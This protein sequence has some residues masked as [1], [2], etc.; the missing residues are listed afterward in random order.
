[1]SMPN[2]AFNQIPRDW[3]LGGFFAEIDG[4]AAATPTDTAAALLIGQMLPTGIAPEA[5]PVLVAGQGSAAAELFGRGSMLHA[6]VVA[7]RANNETM[8][9]YVIPLADNAEGAAAAQT[10]TV[11]GP[12]TAAGTIALWIA[13]AT[14]T[15]IG[16]YRVSVG[17]ASGDAA[18][19]VAAAIAT[20]INAA[21]DLPVTAAAVGAVVTVT[22]RHK[23]EAANE[24]RIQHSLSGEIG[25]EALPAGVALAIPNSG[26][27]AGGTA[28]PDITAAI[29]AMGDINFDYIGMPYTDSAS[30]NAMDAEMD[31]RWN[32]INQIWGLY[33]TARTASLSGLTTFGGTRNGKFGSCV[34]GFDRSSP[35]YL[36][37]ARTVAKV[38]AALFN[39][40]ARALIGLT[41]QGEIA[42]PEASSFTKGD[43]NQLLWS[44]L[45]VLDRQSDKTVV[46]NRMISMYR[47]NAAGDADEAFLDITT[48]ATLQRIAREL[49]SVINSRYILRRCILVKDGDEVAEGIPVCAPQ[50][51]KGTLINHYATLVTLG[52]TED[53][54]EFAK[55]LVVTKVGTRLN[56]LYRP[57]LANPLYTVATQ[58]QF[59]LDFSTF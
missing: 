35:G 27:L 14:K 46:T 59:S 36:T 10:I 43:K 34:A 19:D 33:F 21:T 41:L 55:R 4:S 31:R 6:M 48:P 7:F 44:G 57:D 22:A 30:L 16:D 18:A 15:A 24:I 11:T 9:L 23:G 29:A 53:V 5:A 20:K 26:Y 32:A 54:E 50:L 13:G 8:P 17:V 39:H 49:K 52:L 58:I 28:N 25:G 3:R 38:G 1:M 51:A 12:A 2:E 40:P 37:T 45:S 56:I 47:L 42:E